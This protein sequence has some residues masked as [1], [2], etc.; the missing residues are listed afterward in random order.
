MIAQPIVSRRSFIAAT[1]SASAFATA[2]IALVQAAHALDAGAVFALASRSRDVPAAWAGRTVI[3][4]G[5]Y[6]ARLARLR[7]LLAATSPARLHLLLDAADR[8]LFDIASHEASPHA[9]AR[10]RKG[11]S[12]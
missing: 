10:A 5:D 4:E 9:R 11:I 1:A 6:C 7:R 8:V 2:N 12:A 3:L